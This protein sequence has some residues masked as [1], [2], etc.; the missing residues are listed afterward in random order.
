[1]AQQSALPEIIDGKAVQS[2]VEAHAI[3]GATVLGQRGGWAVLVRYGALERAVAAQ[4]ARTP[5]LWRNLTTAAA[6]VRDEL[7]LA[8]FEVD[9][10]AH[11]PDAGRRRRPDQA[12][13]LRQ[14]RAAAEHDAW[15]RAEVQKTLDRIDAGEIGLLD[16]DAWSERS[17]AKRAE[18]SRRAAAQGG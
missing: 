1:M 12:E 14:Q 2:L 9:A 13:R 18:L 7:G 3:R 11:E 10:Q 6:Y 4:R 17:A 8:R 16:E 15:F 5:R